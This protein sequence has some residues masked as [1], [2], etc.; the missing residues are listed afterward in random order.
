VQALYWIDVCPASRCIQVGGFAGAAIDVTGC[1]VGKDARLQVGP[2]FPD[3]S[4]SVWMN[5][6]NIHGN[7]IVIVGDGQGPRGLVKL[8]EST[9]YPGGNLEIRLADE[10]NQQ[11][12]PCLP[13]VSMTDTNLLPGSTI[14]IDE[15]LLASGAVS[16]SP[17]VY[18]ST[19]LQI[20]G[21]MEDHESSKLS[22]ILLT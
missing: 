3:E 12:S 21:A 17:A 10:L 1:Y 9:V 4:V 14:R 19:S 6:V 18:A 8:D 7:V 16:W 13:T 15:R 22:V 2:V 20:M 5:R 11:S